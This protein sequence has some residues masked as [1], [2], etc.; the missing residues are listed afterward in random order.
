MTAPALAAAVASI[1]AA[2]LP[3]AALAL[4]AALACLKAWELWCRA[5]AWEAIAEALDGGRRRRSRWT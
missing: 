4:G 5:R 1:A 3:V 2:A